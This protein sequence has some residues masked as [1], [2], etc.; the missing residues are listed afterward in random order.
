MRVVY[1]CLL[2]NHPNQSQVLAEAV[3]TSTSEGEYTKHRTVSTLS[4]H[5][6]SHNGCS[7]LCVKN[8]NV[9]SLDWSSTHTPR[10]PWTF[11]LSF[12]KG[13]IQFERLVT[14]HSHSDLSEC[15]TTDDTFVHSP[16]AIRVKIVPPR[17]LSYKALDMITWKAQI[18]WKQHL[19]VKN[20]FPVLDF[21]DRCMWPTPFDRAA[22]EICFGSLDQL[23]SQFENREIT[24]W[25]ESSNGTT[26]LTVGAPNGFCVALI[27]TLQI[28]EYLII[29][30]CCSPLSMGILQ[31]FDGPRT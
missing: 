13:T 30:V 26:L 9:W 31:L 2:Q 27:W 22:N 15:E 16:P 14:Q 20:I 21:R 18:G 12:A 19:R 23:R 28:A 6:S 7:A 8:S 11:G 5:P 17:W 4:S 1:R 10:T 29:L 3:S 24:P 25:D